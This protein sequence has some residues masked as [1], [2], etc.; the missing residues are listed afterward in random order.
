MNQDLGP[1][2]ILEGVGEFL[3]VFSLSCFLTVK[4]QLC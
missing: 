2:A 4:Q 3:I 1:W